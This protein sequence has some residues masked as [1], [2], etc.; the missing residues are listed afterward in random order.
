M[1]LKKELK[2]AP[3]GAVGI[4]LWPI[5]RLL[6]W[7]L[8]A[9]GLRFFCVSYPN[10]IGHLAIEPDCYLKDVELGRVAPA[11]TTTMLLIP[12]A[13]ANPCLLDYWRP[14]FPVISNRFLANILKPLRKHPAAWSDGGRY[15]IFR[16]GIATAGC[17]A[18]YAAW[19]HRPP[20][21]RLNESHAARGEE[22]LR[23]LGVP[24]GAWFVC[25][26]SRETGYASKSD[27]SFL[28]RNSS[29][30]SYRLAM[31]EIVARGGWCVRMGEPSSSILEPTQAVIDYRHSPLRSDWMDV[32]LCA[33]CRFFL[34][35]TSGLFLVS[36]VFGVPTALAHMAPM[37]AAYSV[38]PND[39]SIPKLVA[40]ANGKVLRVS[41]AF[42]SGVARYFKTVNFDRG[43]MRPIENSAEE[44]RELVIEMMERLEGRAKYTDE[45]ERLQDAFRRRFRP[46]D[47]SYGSA[48]RIGRD[49]LRR[50]AD[51]L[52]KEHAPAPVTGV[53]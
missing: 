6:S 9:L 38:G 18:T 42:Q 31:R 22:T 1:P 20:I 16:R 11:R 7:V 45:D 17:Y 37:A 44:I 50:H 35:N 40:D 32:F 43:G 15:A 25:V 36:S 10:G 23:E 27:K 49:F 12:M 4:F 33:S 34:G 21:L 30:D 8:A 48:A 19:G 2:K 5:Y 13:P 53:H 14:F 41:D 46:N 47:Y 24:A 3:V 52:V 28:H 26:H 29:I 39:I 51:L